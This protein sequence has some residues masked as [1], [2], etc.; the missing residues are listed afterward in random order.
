MEPPDLPAMARKIKSGF[1]RNEESVV[2]GNHP[3]E[4]IKRVKKTLPT[5]A[6]GSYGPSGRDLRF[7]GIFLL[8]ENQCESI[9]CG[10]ERRFESFSTRLLH[11]DFP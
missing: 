1:G 10:M 6:V 2:W 8:A 7:W 5:P 11:F 3:L 4:P 9:G